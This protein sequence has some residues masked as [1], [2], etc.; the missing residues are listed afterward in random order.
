MVMN[1]IKI[2]NLHKSY[3]SLKVLDGLNLNVDKGDVYGFVGSN[4][5]GKTTTMNIITK[6]ITYDDGEIVINNNQPFKLGY[7]PETP[8]LFPYLTGVEYLNYIAKCCNYQGDYNKRTEE[9]LKLVKLLKASTRKISGY[10]RGM[11]QRLG[12]ASAIYDNPDL[13]ILDEPTSALDPKGRLEVINIINDLKE[14]GRTIILS[15]H[16]LDDVERVAT[17][18]GILNNGKIALEDTLSNIIKKSQEM[19]SYQVLVESI[20]QE[21]ISNLNSLGLNVKDKQNKLEIDA[22]NNISGND[23]LKMLLNESLQIIKFEEY[24]YNL[25]RVYIEVTENE[26]SN[27]ND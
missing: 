1:M 18:I 25:E 15:S 11:I 26:S 22:L 3:N 8:T 19:K 23:I 20:T 10:S 16:I 12:I 2:K 13:L 27:R 9:V 14:G 24:R 6:L 5:S 21:Q 7:L 4:G 17:K